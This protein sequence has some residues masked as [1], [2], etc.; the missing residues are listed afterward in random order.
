MLL[1]IIV[2]Q[3]QIYGDACKMEA[4]GRRH[5]HEGAFRLAFGLFIRVDALEFLEWENTLFLELLTQSPRKRTAFDFPKFRA[6]YHCGVGAAG[7]SHRRNK[8]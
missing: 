3:K 4:E 6:F 2:F 7:C 8:H 5:R 1:A